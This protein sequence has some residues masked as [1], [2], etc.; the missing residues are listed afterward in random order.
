MIKFLGLLSKKKK[1]KAKLAANI[2]VNLL[3]NVIEVGFVEIKDFINNNNNLE[4]NPNLTDLDIDWFRNIVFLGNIRNL[5]T[6]F[7]E[8]DSATLRGYILDELHK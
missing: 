4:D 5:D 3:N 7:E 6:F 8:K 2:Y 1:V